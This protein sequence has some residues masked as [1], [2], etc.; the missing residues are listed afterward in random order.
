[1]LRQFDDVRYDRIAIHIS[2]EIQLLLLLLLLL[3]TL[4]NRDPDGGFKIRKYRKS[5][6][7]LT[8]RAVTI[9]Q[10]VMQQNSVKALYQD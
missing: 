8:I 10:T 2:I 3:F 6:V 5:S 4:G 9:W 1:M 7:C